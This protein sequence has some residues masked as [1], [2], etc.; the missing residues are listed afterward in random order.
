MFHVM[1]TGKEKKV[2]LFIILYY[3]TPTNKKGHCCDTA[4][5]LEHLDSIYRESVEALVILSQ[6]FS[7]IL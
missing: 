5:F 6:R 2:N 3:Y 4:G 7:K 1:T